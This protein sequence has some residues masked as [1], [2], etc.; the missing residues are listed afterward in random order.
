M[1]D[2]EQ[3][4][5]ASGIFGAWSNGNSGPA[6]ETSGSPGSRIINYSVGRLRRQQHD[7]RLLRHAAP[8]RTARSSRT[9]PRP[10]ST[11]ARAFPATP[12]AAST[13]P[14]WPRRTSPA[15]SRCSGRPRPSLIGDIDGTRALL[16]DTAVDTPT[17]QCGGTADDN[18]VFGEGRLDALALLERGPGRRHR[19]AGRHGHRRGHRRP[20]RR[21]DGRVDRRV[22]A[23]RS[24]PE[25][26]A[27]TRSGSPPATTRDRLDVRL[28]HRDR[29]RSPWP[30]ARPRRQDF[31]LAAA[32]TVT[33][34]GTVTDGSGHGWPLYAKVDVAGPAR[35]RVHR[36]E[37]RRSTPSRCPATRRTPSRRR[38][39]TPATRRRPRTSR[40]VT[41]TRPQDVALEVDSADLHGARLRVQLRRRHT[42]TSTPA[43][44]RTAGRS[45]TTSA[46]A[47]S[48]GSTTRA[49]GATSPAERQLRDHGQ[50]LLRHRRQPGHLAGQPGGRHV[51][52]HRTRPRVQAGLQQPR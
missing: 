14:R 26:T 51:D 46:T 49:A 6:C 43:P 28:R 12:T 13:A 41:A 27:P 47:R 32:P 52:A 17:P 15:P 3:A 48:G 35:R 25:P 20:A 36:P 29:R 5:A 23:A 10:A 37:H 7:R 9:S 21:R 30:R 1:E 42:R 24:R 4:W 19:H 31:A 33:L 44:C 34:S 16:D 22:R 50:R 38:R 40:S 11:S 18:N 8:A 2:I 39:S 45:R